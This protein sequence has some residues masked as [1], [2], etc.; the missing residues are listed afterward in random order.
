MAAGGQAVFAKT[1]VTKEDD[2]RRALE[3]AKSEFGTLDVLVN[4]A[5]W[6]YPKKDTLTV[7]EADYDRR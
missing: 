6:T 3:T 1:D 4:N 2:W 7:T 5:G